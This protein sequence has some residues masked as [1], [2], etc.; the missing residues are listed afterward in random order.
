MAK[1]ASLIDLRAII[2]AYLESKPDEVFRI[3][4]LRKAMGLANRVSYDVMKAILSRMADKGLIGRLT[5][6]KSTYYGSHKAVE[7][8]KSFLAKQRKSF[9]RKSSTS[10]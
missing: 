7:T 6:A 4:E 10:E 1:I 2:Q 8:A 3:N 9:E 5:I